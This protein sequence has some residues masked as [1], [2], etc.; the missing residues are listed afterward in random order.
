MFELNQKVPLT[1]IGDYLS[2]SSSD[3]DQLE[4]SETV[5]LSNN[6]ETNLSGD[7]QT[8]KKFRKC[9]YKPRIRIL[10]GDIRRSFADMYTNVWNSNDLSLMYGFLDTYFTPDFQQ[11]TLQVAKHGMVHEV[12]SNSAISGIVS[13]AKFWYLQMLLTPDMT[14]TIKESTVVEALDKSQNRV[15]VR[16]ST[17]G[18]RL[19][20]VPN[21]CNKALRTI[22]ITQ[23][24]K[25]LQHEAREN[26][27]SVG[28][29][30]RLSSSLLRLPIVD[31]LMRSSQAMVEGFPLFKKPV[32]REIDCTFTMYTN[33]SNHVT[34]FVMEMPLFQKQPPVAAVN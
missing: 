23:E 4:S 18:C 17:K 32:E 8:D 9:Y 5:S 30:R 7:E 2:T 26:M 28:S 6:S 19:Y 21:S 33:E 3:E 14:I 25:R 24:E 11:E 22:P 31:S 13:V 15:V 1:F 29:K 27:T 34:R 12:N 16:I 10:R 20:D